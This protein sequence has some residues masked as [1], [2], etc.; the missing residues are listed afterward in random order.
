MPRL[1]KILF[2]LLLAYPWAAS[3]ALALSPADLLIVYNRKY[4]E[5]QAVANYYAAKRQVPPANLVAVAVATAEQISRQDFD[6]DLLPPVRQAAGRLKAQGRTPAVLL[7]YGMPLRVEGAG[8]TDADQAF[9][10]LAA[11]RVRE[12]RDLVLKMTREL[13]RLTEAP[14]AAAKTS[15]RLTLPPGRVLEIAR[16][17]LERAVQYLG[18]KDPSP[19]AAARL[20]VMSLL[21]R[22]GGTSR[23]AR[24][25]AEELTQGRDPDPGQAL[26][27]W[28]AVLYRDLEEQLFT[29]VL[30]DTALEI[31]TAVRFTEGVAGEL[32]FWENLRTMTGKPEKTAALDSELT[33][34]LRD[35]YQQA[36]WLPNPFNAR[37]DRLPFIKDLRAKTL[38]VARLDGPTP[39]IAKRLVDDALAT[40]KAGLAGTFYID[41]RGLEGEP[42]S[43]NYA[44]YDQHLVNLYDRVKEKSTMTVVIDRNPELF[45]PGSCPDAALY[46]G[47][48]SLGNYV[49][50]C[51]WNRGAVA[52]HVASSEAVTLKHP[53]SNVWCKRMLEEGVAATLGPVAEPYLASFPL[54][55]EFFPLL[56][57]GKLPLMEVYFRTT[58]YVSWMQTLIGDPLY[59]PFK[60]NPALR[61]PGQAKTKSEEAIKKGIL[62]QGARGPRP[63]PPSPKPPPPTP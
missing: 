49:A 5:S 44:W 50:S 26:L 54:P 15:R 6:Q 39:E 60:K 52:Y 19:D 10:E 3:A 38:M 32:Q 47:W 17:S 57:S 33:L 43:G 13:D 9:K 46:V 4:P 2:L 25:Q 62:G 24:A 53:G 7:V 58:P 20:K 8:E 23:Q 37:Y 14:D 51:K 61:L 29:G 55:D 34:A 16:T 22:L 48:Y 36:R 40:E 56:M 30:P 31:A 12:Y 41:A 27:A 21:I 28:H 35:G 59:T 18:R 42:K 1:S 63:L 45:P 11:V